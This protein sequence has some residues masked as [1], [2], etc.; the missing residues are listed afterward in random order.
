MIVKCENCKLIGKTTSVYAVRCKN[1]LSP[2]YNRMRFWG[3]CCRFG[4][5]KGMSKEFCTREKTGSSIVI[6]IKL[7]D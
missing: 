5:E 7:K 4:I 1:P 3:D 2:E 6:S